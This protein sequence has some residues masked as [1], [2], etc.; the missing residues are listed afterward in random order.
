MKHAAL[1]NCCQAPLKMVEGEYII[2][3]KCYEAIEERETIQLPDLSWKM[4]FIILFFL[5]LLRSLWMDLY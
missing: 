4:V 2:C 3:L 1:S 5:L